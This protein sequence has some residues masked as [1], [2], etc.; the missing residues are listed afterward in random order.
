MVLHPLSNLE[1]IIL[2]LVTIIIST[3]S[4]IFIE[5]P[6]RKKTYNIYLI[7]TRNVILS[8]ILS[9]F[10]IILVSNYLISNDKYVKLNK[11]KQA[12]INKLEKDNELFKNFEAKATDR[13]RNN[14]YFQN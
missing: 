5:L 11:E 10:S 12:T 14:I 13:I 8:F 3:F 2:I 7:S 9:F 4:Y 6:F 1:K